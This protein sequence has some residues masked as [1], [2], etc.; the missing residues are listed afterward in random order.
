MSALA[1]GLLVASPPLGDPN[2]ERSVVLVAAHNNE[3]AFGWVINGEELMSM[4]EL[5]ERADMPKVDGAQPRGT[6]RRGGPVGREQ[7][8][9][10]YRT[11]D[12]PADVED[13]MDV[14][15]GITASSSRKLLTL[16]TQ[17]TAPFPIIGVAG[18]AGW[19]PEQLENEIG[20]GSW[21]PM[22]AD[23]SLLFEMEP[24]DLWLKA[25]ERAGVTAMSFT[26]RVVGSA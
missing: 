26:T 24:A 18:Y 5:L 19:G 11:A 16:L 23:A 14:G 22:D 3:G 1:P 4:A 8:W 6:V 17:G 12:R 15:C 20:S 9:L 13:Q 21:L 7:V 2:F 25:Y 10:L